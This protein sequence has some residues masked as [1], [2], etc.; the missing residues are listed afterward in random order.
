MIF[1]GSSA[2]ASN[3][4]RLEFTMSAS[5]EKMPIAAVSLSLGEEF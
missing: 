5:R 2:L 4:L 1:S 3:A